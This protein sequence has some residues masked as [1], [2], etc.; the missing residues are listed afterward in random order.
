MYGV[1]NCFTQHW[2]CYILDEWVQYSNLFNIESFLVNFDQT[3]NVNECFFHSAWFNIPL[4][5]KYFLSIGANIN[6]KYQYGET[7]LHIAARYNYIEEANFFISN[8]ANI[9]EEGDGESTALE[10]AEMYNSKE[11]EELLISCW[12]FLDFFFLNWVKY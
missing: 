12:S 9:N 11:T 3:N 1:C 4:L 5:C 10:I 8:G 2:F 7:V 6:E